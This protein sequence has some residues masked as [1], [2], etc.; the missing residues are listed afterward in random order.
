MFLRDEDTERTFPRP[1]RIC[2]SQRF[3]SNRSAVFSE[4]KKDLT[5]SSASE[6]DEIAPEVDS[7]PYA[8]YFQQVRNG[9]IVRMALLVWY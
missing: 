8:R 7:T 9:I 2:E 1:G 3:V 6:V 5:I 4:A